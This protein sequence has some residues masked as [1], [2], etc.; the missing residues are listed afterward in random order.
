MKL[1]CAVTR[2][3][4]T[5]AQVLKP[6]L[7]ANRQV[8]VGGMV[9]GRATVLIGVFNGGV[10]CLNGLVRDR[11]IAARDGVQVRLGGNLR[12]AHGSLSVGG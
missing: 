1:S 11:E 8:D 12:L 5:R 10:G 3:L 9:V 4:E 6:V 7:V 2:G